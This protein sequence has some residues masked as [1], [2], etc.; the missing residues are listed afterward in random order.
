MSRHRREQVMLDL[1]VEMPGKPVIEP[2][3]LDIAGGHILQGGPVPIPIEINVHWNMIHL[4][5]VNEP[6]A[7]EHAI[8][9]VKPESTPEA[10]KRL[11][12]DEVLNEEGAHPE[13]ICPFAVFDGVI[14]VI[15]MEVSGQ[16]ERW[17]N[18]VPI[19]M[20]EAVRHKSSLR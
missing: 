4:R 2:R 16:Q 3:V 5:D 13:Q 12:E 11:I 17:S 9:H 1:E 20:L 8:E 14:D 19:M 10:K 6:V 18:Q 7:L 15:D